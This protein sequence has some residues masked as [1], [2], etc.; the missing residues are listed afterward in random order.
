MENVKTLLEIKVEIVVN[1]DKNIE[2]NP[3]TFYPQTKAKNKITIKEFLEGLLKEKLSAYMKNCGPLLTPKNLINY[4]Q[5]LRSVLTYFK[6]SSK[7]LHKK[8]D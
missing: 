4:K 7:L 1:I 5:K 8:I 2:A 6:L 3:V